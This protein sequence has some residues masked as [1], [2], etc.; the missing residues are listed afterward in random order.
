VGKAL[1]EHWQK[2]GAVLVCLAVGGQHVHLLAKMPNT[3]PRR[4]AGFAKRHVWFVARD[5]GWQGKIWGKRGKAVPIRDREHQLNVYRYIL[6][7]EEQ[8]AWI[9]SMIDNK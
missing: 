7:H 3:E 1:V 5:K 8:G 9:W 2:L 4:W 6:A